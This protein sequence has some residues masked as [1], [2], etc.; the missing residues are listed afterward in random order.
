MRWRWRARALLA[1]LPSGIG[2]V[3]S[4]LIGWSWHEDK[5]MAC[6]WYVGAG[7]WLGNAISSVARRWPL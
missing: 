7:L 2:A 6:S 1:G 5:L 3:A 4:L